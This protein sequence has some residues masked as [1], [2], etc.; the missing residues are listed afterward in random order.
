MAIITL[1]DL[2]TYAGLDPDNIEEDEKLNWIIDAVHLSIDHYVGR[3]LIET[4]YEGELYDGPGT[5]ALC[6]RNYP[7]TEVTAVWLAGVEVPASEPY[8]DTPVYG[9]YGSYYI[10]N[11]DDGI[12]FHSLCWPSG[13]AIIKIDYK[14]GYDTIPPDIFL[15]TLEMAEFYRKVTKKTAISSE[16]LGSYSTVLY[17]SLGSMDGLLTIPSIPFMMILNHYR[18]NSHPNLVY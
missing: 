18:A 15:G 16:G 12:L 3:T 17:N 6:L 11:A 8:S 4:E 7:V 5:E 1:E 2:K 9:S 13:R 14:A 10:Q